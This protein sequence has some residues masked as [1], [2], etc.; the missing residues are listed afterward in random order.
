[1]WS[2]GEYCDIIVDRN[3]L[4]QTTIHTPLKTAEVT[5]AI[6]DSGT[7]THCLC[8]DSPYKLEIQTRNGLKATQ[9]E[10]TNIQAT[11]EYELDM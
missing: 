4:I 2:G 5:D 7:T 11:A 8:I 10:G 6:V 9:P 3:K 1:M